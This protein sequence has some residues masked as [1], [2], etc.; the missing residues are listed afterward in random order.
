[1]Q[2]CLPVHDGEHP[3]PGGPLLDPQSDDSTSVAPI[4]VESR[5]LG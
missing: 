2:V 3:P 1:M 4:N 5:S